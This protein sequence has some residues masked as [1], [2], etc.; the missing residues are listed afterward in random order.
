MMP[1]IV[2]APVLLKMSVPLS[3]M[4]AMASRV[5]VAPPVPICSVP[6]LM[7]VPAE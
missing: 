6:A 4:G 2:E 3:V 1:L 5:P 7:V